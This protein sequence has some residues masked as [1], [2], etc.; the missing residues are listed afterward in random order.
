MFIVIRIA[1]IKRS[2]PGWMSMRSLFIC[3]RVKKCRKSLLWT[4]TQL[5]ALWTFYCNVPLHP[6]SC[7]QRLCA[8]NCV[9]DSA[10][11]Y[12][13]KFRWNPVC[14]D[15]MGGEFRRRIF[16]V[17]GEWNEIWEIVG[18]ERLLSTSV[19]HRKLDD[20]IFC[21][22]VETILKE[23][24]LEQT[25]DEFCKANSDRTA[26]IRRWYV[27][28]LLAVLRSTPNKRETFIYLVSDDTTWKTL[29]E[30]QKKIS[31]TSKNCWASVPTILL[32]DR[33]L[34]EI[35]IEVFSRPFWHG[36]QWNQQ[37]NKNRY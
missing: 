29:Q 21:L 17:E 15:E 37:S 33:F 13:S 18:L 7:L 6:S 11:L 22:W 12:V 14:L 35:W 10:R 1:V 28:K 31:Q 8:L 20:T 3:I 4:G 25:T 32:R 26:V 23:N 16:Q 9:R 19:F 2:S 5:G 30:K 34:S 24:I 27:D 36:L